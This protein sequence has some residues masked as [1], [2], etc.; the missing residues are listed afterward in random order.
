[1]SKKNKILL[2]TILLTSVVGGTVIPAVNYTPQAAQ[3]VLQVSKEVPAQTTVNIT[4]LVGSKFDKEISNKDGEEQTLEK[5]KEAL[6]TD[7]KGLAGVTFAAYKLP[8]NITE[9]QIKELKNTKTEEQLKE[10]AKKHNLTLTE[11]QTLN[12]TGTDGKTTWTVDKEKY[13]KYIVVE[14]SAPAGVSSALGVPFVMSFPMSA[15]DGSGYLSTVNVYP[16][17]VQGNEP[18][19]GKDVD[20]LANNN[21]SYKIG[22]EFTFILKGTIPTNIQDYELYDLTDE[23]DSQLTPTLDGLEAK[24]GTQSLV[25]DTDY[26]VTLTGQNFKFSLT[27]AGIKK[28]SDSVDLTKRDL[29]SVDG[30][31][32]VAENTDEKPFIQVNVKAKINDKATLVK[33]IENKVK[34][35][36]DNKKDG[37]KKPG[38]PKESEIVKVYT[39]GKL[40]KKVD[41]DDKTALTGA[42]FDLLNEDKQPVIWTDE[43]IKANQT[44]ITAGKFVGTPAVNQPV[45]LKSAADGT[46]EISGLG[47]GKEM[48]KFKNDKIVETA[49]QAGNRTYYLKETKAPEGYVI[50][51][52]DIKFEVGVGS[53]NEVQAINITGT[54]QDINNSKRPL[55]PNTGGIG[56]VIFI[57]AGLGVMAFA[58]FGLKK[59]NK[60]A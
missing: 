42:E 4:K 8:D 25:K 24:Y 53:T 23:F 55:I 58:A 31:D 3:A 32:E 47:Y 37:N 50:L 33:D 22:E 34:L 18:R 6:G 11:E 57:V 20:H 60:D 54:A 51:A 26:T 13:G 41:R 59:R 56:S 38:T 30:S 49:K 45:K 28:I 10:V 5:L 19:P 9:D 36:F 15:S 44:A 14:K 12:V 17:N 2:S 48:T 27:E 52:E 39:G 43:L 1:M 16:K 40:F 7:V 35:E 46:F 29:V 21:A